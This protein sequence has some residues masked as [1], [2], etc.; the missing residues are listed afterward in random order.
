[1]K[2]DRRAELIVSAMIAVLATPLIVWLWNYSTIAAERRVTPREAESPW[3][4]SI[5]ARGDRV[6]TNHWRT[7][8]AYYGVGRAKLINGDLL[9]ATKYFRICVDKSP[10]WSEPWVASCIMLGAIAEHVGDE[11][12]AHEYYARYMSGA[13]PVVFEARSRIK[14]GWRKYRLMQQAQGG[15]NDA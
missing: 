11:K 3:I 10:V 6:D 1:M 8:R 9:G 13:C 4:S 12:T 5:Q 14:H 2:D 15:K 7:Y